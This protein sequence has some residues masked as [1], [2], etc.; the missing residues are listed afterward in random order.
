MTPTKD[1]EQR[2]VMRYYAPGKLNTRK[3][4]QKV[5]AGIGMRPTRYRWAWVGTAAALLVLVV[6]GAALYFHE[7]TTTLTAKRSVERYTLADGTRVTLAPG[8][9]LSYKGDNCRRVEIEGKVFLEIKHDADNPFMVMDQNYTINDI[10]TKLMVEETSAGTSVYV[11][12]GTVYFASTANKKPGITLNES[13]AAILTAHGNGPKRIAHPAGNATTWATGQFHFDN[14]PLADV[15]RDL[16]AYYGVE[17]SCAD[18]GKHLSGDFEAVSLDEVVT[19]IEQTLNV[20][21]VS[22]IP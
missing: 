18:T 5:K 10:G 3:A 16:S 11:T 15:L 12:E 14:T 13:D 19:I 4:L 8:A 20:R 7:P 17:L 1:K 6:A 9:T 22:R 2:F 21:I